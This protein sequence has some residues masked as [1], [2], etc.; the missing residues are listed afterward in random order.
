MEFANWY[1]PIHWLTIDA[2][3]AWSHA[4]FTDNEQPAGHYVPEALA[5]TFDGGIG[6]HNLDGWAKDIA[7]GLRMRYFG[8]RSLTQD[9]RSAPAPPRFSMP[10]SAIDSATIGPPASTSSTC[11]TPNPATSIII[12]CHACRV[13]RWPA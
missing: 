10:I 12:T 8:P 1:T 5:A 2:D 11:W 6:V 9:D 3:Y 13:S 4:C 7:A